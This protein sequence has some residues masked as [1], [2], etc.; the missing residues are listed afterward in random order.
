MK[1]L[2]I[3][4]NM[5]IVLMGMNVK[6]QTWN[7][8]AENDYSVASNTNMNQAILTLKDNSRKYYNTAD[9]TSIDISGNNITV[10]QNA[11]EYT[12][13]DKIADITFRKAEQGGDIENSEDGVQIIKA[14]GWLESAYVEF[15]NFENA[16]NY[17]VYV[18]GGQY[19][20][21]TKIDNQLIRS[22]GTYNRADAMGLNSGTYSLK[23][24][25]V[26]NDT[27]VSSAANEAKNII[28]KNFNRDGYAHYNAI[29][30]IGA[31]NN[32][33]TLKDGARVI[34]VSKANAK[35]IQL[36]MNVGKNE[37]TRTGIQD[38]IQAY[39]KGEETR[40]LAIRIIGQLKKGDMP[41]LGS[42]AIGLQVK[43]KNQNMN[44]TIEGV[45]NDATFHGFGVLMRNCRYVELRNFAVM[46]HPEDGISFDTNNEH[47]WGHNLDI[48]Y[49]ENKGGDKA[50]GDGSFDVKGTLYCTV[51][52]NH[53]WD[54]GK[55][56]LNSNG[57]E[58]DFVT[59]HHN[60]YDHS[61]S[62]HPRVRKSK[63]L[64]VFNN[65]F[66][67]NAKYGVG[68][69]TGSCIFVEKNYYRNCKYPMLISKQGSDIHNGVG[70]SSD[71]KGTFSSEDGGMI[72]AF[73]NY[74]TG[75]T[76][77]EPYIAGDA[78]Y[79]KHFDAYVVEN[80]NDEVP[81][82]VVTLQGGTGY[83]NFDI[84][85]DFYNYTPDAKEDVPTIVTGA[86]GAGRCEK[87]DFKWI[88]NN[89]TEDGNSD[90]INDLSNALKNYTG[91]L[92]KVY[93]D[94]GADS[95]EQGGDEGEGGEQGGE[96][97]PEGTIFA[98]FDGSP[99][100]S[101]FIANDNYGDGKITYNGIY[102]K[103]GEKMDS[104][105]AITF[106]PTKDYNMSLVLATAKN[107]RDVKINGTTTS[108]PG[109]ENTEGAYYQLD[110]IAITAGTEYTLTKGS[111]E[112]IVMLII[113][114]PID[115]EF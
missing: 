7:T 50:K 47:V 100:H 110:P 60:W 65:Y 40:P 106:T 105:G 34:Y 49:G 53:F 79:S 82:E 94:M 3:L 44:L 96:T 69:T 102:Y 61:D 75:Q 51:S 73:D 31:Y 114:E 17:N 85:S 35:T 108:I 26:I 104:K 81:A 93:G 21:Y 67:G 101:M 52:D 63:R 43:G 29:A 30:G 95:G 2:T 78:T 66:D 1:K 115:N 111:A 37:E 12:F 5:V 83:N 91:E 74:M 28:V 10:K 87:G 86:Y 32:D 113:L 107:G 14:G 109:I 15:A 9:V 48:F 42:S 58:V 54:A 39:E 71:T 8:A 23:V 97:T 98:S 27:E 19:S 56:T 90:V 38:I 55:C 18:K 6:A 89:A 20:E 62:R 76:S 88:F 59:Y 13:V 77:F 103:K 46:M 68:A 99:S 22:Y 57:D 11:G 41:T 92:V 80:R 25:P 84:A 33:G 24:V 36:S 72:K 112:S 70:S 64:H 16:E 45:G 4:L